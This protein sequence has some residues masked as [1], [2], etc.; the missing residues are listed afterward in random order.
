M[1]CVE[2]KSK[3]VKTKKWHPCDWC[4]EQID[5]GDIAAYRVYIYEGDFNHGWMHPEC[6]EAMHHLDADGDFHWIPGEF[7]RGKCYA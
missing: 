3:V 2:L 1:S 5:K 6:S 7:L 4:A